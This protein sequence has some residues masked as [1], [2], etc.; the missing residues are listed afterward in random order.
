MRNKALILFLCIISVILSACSFNGDE[1]GVNEN[2]EKM[3]RDTK[4]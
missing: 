1:K 3:K 4:R 2:G